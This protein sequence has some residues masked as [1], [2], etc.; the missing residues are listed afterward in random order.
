MKLTLVVGARPNFMK[1]A[2]IIR[3]IEYKKKDGFPLSY[4]LIHTGQH[5]DLVMNHY[6]FDQ[7]HIPKPDISFECG[8]GTDSEQTA[9]IMKAF[10]QELIAHKPDTVLVVGDVNSTM[11]C[12]IVTKKQNI[13]LAHVEAGIRSGDKSMPE[14]INRIVTDAISDMYFTTSKSADE[15]LFKIR[16]EESETALFLG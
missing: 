15:L 4:R 8:G 5:Y 12:S 6:F 7:L 11:A 9:C 16:V 3:A 1:I 14:E 13:P 10:E 2:P